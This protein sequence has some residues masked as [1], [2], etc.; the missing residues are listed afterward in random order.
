VFRQFI[1]A[2]MY[3]NEVGAI[4]AW[5]IFFN[6]TRHRRFEIVKFLFFWTGLKILAWMA[7]MIISVLTCCLLWIFLIF[8]YIWAV[9]VLPVLVFFRF[10]SLEFLSQFGDSEFNFFEP[11]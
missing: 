2:L 10:Y 7:V 1:I 8:P 4:E 3:K 9:A 6:L 5:S 11:L